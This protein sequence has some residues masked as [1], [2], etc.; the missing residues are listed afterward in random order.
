VVSRCYLCGRSTQRELVT[1]ENWWGN[2]LALVE[3]V[4]AWVC[5]NCGEMYF[6]AET[7]RGLDRLHQEPPIV[8]RIVSVP[9]YAYAEANGDGTHVLDV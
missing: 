4:P 2:D 7:S 8:Q 9:V 1:A 6:D 3:H 5:Q